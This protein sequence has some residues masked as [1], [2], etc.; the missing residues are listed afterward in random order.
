[1]GP[2][3]DGSPVEEAG[4]PRRETDADGRRLTTNV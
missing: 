3:E 4:S 1:M 2:L